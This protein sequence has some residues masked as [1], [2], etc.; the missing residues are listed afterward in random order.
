MCNAKLLVCPLSVRARRHRFRPTSEQLDRT[1]FKASGVLH[2]SISVELYKK[3]ESTF[4]T[5]PYLHRLGPERDAVKYVTSLC[6]NN[7]MMTP[8]LV[9]DASSL[10]DRLPSKIADKRF[11]CE[12]VHVGSSFEETVAGDPNKFKFLVTL[13]RFEDLCAPVP[14]EKSGSFRLQCKSAFRRGST[15]EEFY[16]DGFLSTTDVKFIFEL[17]LREIVNGYEFWENETY[18]AMDDIM[19]SYQFTS[20]EEYTILKLKTHQLTGPEERPMMHIYLIPCVRVKGWWPTVAVPSFRNAAIWFKE[21]VLKHDCGLTFAQP[22]RV[23]A[24]VRVEEKARYSKTN[25]HLLFAIHESHLIKS[26]PPIIKTAFMICKWLIMDDITDIDVSYNAR[27]F[28][29]YTLKTAVMTCLAEVETAPPPFMA[30]VSVP[31]YHEVTKWVREILG[32][33]LQFVNQ[34]CVLMFFMPTWRLPV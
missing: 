14:T 18:F 19:P 29:N 30:A 26:C 12:T 22:R 34:G 32:R 25:A 33:L 9:R 27:L 17:I 13:T 15:Y 3:M 28:S 24:M 20:G 10:V 31:D 1:R 23:Y 8:C 16:S 4:D 5:I 6:K 2:T 11:A 7:G 21:E